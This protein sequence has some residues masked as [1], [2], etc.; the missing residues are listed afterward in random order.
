[1]SRDDEPAERGILS[2]H[3][4]A[5]PGL[6]AGLAAGRTAV[7]LALVVA[8]VGPVLWLAKAA[9]STTRDT[10]RD[11][12]ALWPGGVQW[13]NL[14]RAWNTV[15]IDTYLANTFWVAGGSS[16]LGVFV[17]VTGGYTLSVLRPRYAKALTGVVLA[18]LFVPSVVVLVPLYLTVLDVPVVGVNLLNSFWAVWLPAAANSFVVLVVKQFFDRLPRELF[19]VAKVDGA[20]PFR[21]FWHLVLPMSRPVV[22]VAVL[23][24]FVTGWKEFLWPL[25]VLTD[26]EKQ[27][28]S[29]ALPRLSETAEMSLLMAGLFISVL[30]PM[31]LFLVFQRQFLRAASQSGAIKG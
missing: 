15:G 22:G 3:D 5:R 21:I 25:L 24:T 27:P 14:D 1:M 18:T 12:F 30:I 26:A 4:L 13:G 8:A 23:L 11:P 2:P 29:V 16:V 20:G 7:L 17:A 19:E 9:V 10:L 31:A 28:L 6:R